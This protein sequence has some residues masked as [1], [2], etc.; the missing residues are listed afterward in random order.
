MTKKILL[1]IFLFQ[2]FL[3]SC[4]SYIVMKHEENI[5]PLTRQTR[6]IYRRAQKFL[7]YLIENNFPFEFAPETKIIK[8]IKDKQNKKIQIH[9]NPLFSNFPFRPENVENINEKLQDYLG[10]RYRKYKATIYTLNQPIE[11]LIPNYYRKNKTNYDHSRLPIATNKTIPIVKNLSEN[12][13][14]PQGLSNRNIALWPSHGWYYNIKKDRWE[15]QRPRIFQ[16]V[17]D[18]L[19][20]SYVLPYLVPMLENSGANVFLPRERDLQTNEVIVDND[21]SSTL[22]CH[23]IE[24][25]STSKSQTLATGFG[26]GSP[27]Y[28]TGENPFQSGTS[29]LFQCD[30][31]SSDLVE[32][33]PEIPETGNYNVYIAYTHSDSN[34][35]QAQYKIYHSGGKTDFTVNQQIGGSTWIYLGNFKFFKGINPNFGKVILNDYSQD[36]TKYISADGIRFGGGMGNVSRHGTISRRPRFVEAARYY[37]QYA[38]IND[39]LVYSF[40][41]DSNDYSDDYKCRGEWVNFLKGSPYGPNKKRNAPG[42]GIPIDLSLAIHTDAGINKEDTLIGTLCIYS[43]NDIDIDLN[44]PDSVSRMANRDLADIVQTQ[45]VNDI[46]IL[47]DPQ[48]P[49]RQLA[50]RQY[51]EVCRPNFPSLLLELFSHQNFADMKY[52]TDPKFRFD[53]CRSIY[54]GMLKFLSVQYNYLPVVQP[55]PVS[56]FQALITDTS[57][58]TLKWKQTPDPLEPNAIADKYIVYTKKDSNGFDNGKVIDS[59]KIILNNINP[60]TIYSFKVCALNQGGKSFPSEILSVCINKLDNEPILIIN[61][62]DRISG[63]EKIDKPRHRGFINSIDQGVPDIYDVT[64]TGQQKEFDPDAEYQNNDNPGWGASYSDFETQ[65]IPGNTRNFAYIHGKAIK[66][67]NRSFM[68]VSDE[69]V[70]DNYIDIKKFKILDLIFGEEKTTYVKKNGKIVKTLYQTFPEKFQKI[71]TAYLESGGNMFLSGAYIGS[72]LNSTKS[73]RT[74]A[75]DILKF[76]L[77]LSHAVRD[78]HFYTINDLFFEENYNFEYNTKLA[79]KIYAVE[80]PDCIIPSGENAKTI[81]RYSENEFSGG[82]CYSGSYNLI[83]FAFPFETIINERYQNLL[84]KKIISVLETNKAKNRE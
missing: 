32:W 38:G 24:P 45:I 81:I 72:D 41:Q 84:M 13:H 46:Q 82:I 1:L 42:L 35:S 44:F 20:L 33:I 78:G 71:I 77:H 10:W 30:S 70:M 58:V 60:D 54:K 7:N 17:E 43:L 49:R 59:C 79:S 16:T 65:I 57:Q 12:L 21:T 36:T 69:A 47:H 39:S 76:N 25:D 51:S 64:F 29:R 40:N 5:T 11:Q 62:F 14:F 55:L 61:C 28:S 15:W 2:L 56:H 50:N 68:S 53:V 80:A 18:L 63:A 67:A 22:L 74:F 23:Y 31:S 26:I 8:I 73:N 4:A 52:G 34:T 19:P 3:S 83:I 66:A 27:P 48:W 6:P 75:S 37:L 9:F